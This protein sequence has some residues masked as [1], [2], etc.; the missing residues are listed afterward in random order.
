MLILVFKAATG[1]YALPCGQVVECIPGLKPT[2]IP[3]APEYVTGTILY[4]GQVVPVVDLCLLIAGSVSP[5][6]FSTRLIVVHYPLGEGKTA[7]LALLAQEV[8]SY[9]EFDPAGA[10]KFDGL[11]VPGAKYL[12][13]LY[14]YRG[15][16]LQFIQ[17]HELLTP[18]A[19]ETLFAR[20]G[21]E[22]VV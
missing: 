12:G 19:R 8:V 3:R 21:Q 7:P 5:G 9:S 4:R 16:M 11:M 6:L 20:A 2:P 17:V 18:E 13:K 1:L 14:K 22:G 15:E 10:A